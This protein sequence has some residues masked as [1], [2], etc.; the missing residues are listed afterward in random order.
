MLTR[1]RTPNFNAGQNV[2]DVW[3]YLNGLAGPAWKFLLLSILGTPTTAAVK[4]LVRIK[5]RGK[6]NGTFLAPAGSA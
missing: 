6:A 1:I 5:I 4:D 3:L 2:A